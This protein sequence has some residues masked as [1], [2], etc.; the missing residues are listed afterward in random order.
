MFF[1]LFRPQAPPV[2][3][4]QQARWFRN[5]ERTTLSAHRGA[6]RIIFRH[7]LAVRGEEEGTL[8]GNPNIDMSSVA[9]SD[10][11]GLAL[12]GRGTALPARVRCGRA[13]RTRSVRSSR[14]NT[15]A[16]A[17]PK[18]STKHTREVARCKPPPQSVRCDRVCL[19]AQQRAG[20]FLEGRLPC[21]T[22]RCRFGWHGMASFNR[23]DLHKVEH[24]S[25]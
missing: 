9:T 12:R 22:T 3:R 14:D 5:T 8:A 18:L 13:H 17:R 23:R 7:V 25:D 19:C 20:G 16:R 4:A 1:G 6:W 10:V 24:Q 15:R 11:C 21:L 2:L